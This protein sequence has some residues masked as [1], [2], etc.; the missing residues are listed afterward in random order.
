MEAGGQFLLDEGTGQYF[1]VPLG[2]G[3][4]GGDPS[5]TGASGYFVPPNSAAGQLSQDPAL[6]TMIPLASD[7]ATTGPASLA[8]GPIGFAQ[9]AAS[10][11]PGVMG[12][13]KGA[14]QGFKTGAPAVEAAAAEAAPAA[15]S[16]W[17]PLKKTLQIGGPILGGVLAYNKQEHNYK[18]EDEAA[19]AKIKAEAQKEAD[20]A[21]RKLQEL[22][23]QERIASDRS[24]QSKLMN[25]YRLKI[26]AF[27]DEQQAQMATE[28]RKAA[29]VPLG[30]DPLE[31]IRIV[32][33]PPIQYPDSQ[34]QGR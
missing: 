22:T 18:L 14:L 23:Y 3:A 10:K 25:E 21:A 24:A 27:K 32:M 31:G 6:S 7:M 33:P 8:A 11:G 16:G 17:G 15:A 26:A 4:A 12:R 34:P 13:L 28:I 20:L 30:A 2:P 29:F 9:Q 19:A 1:W 5:V